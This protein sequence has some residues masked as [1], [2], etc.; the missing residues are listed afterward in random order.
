MKLKKL[1]VLNQFIP[2]ELIKINCRIIDYNNRSLKIDF[3]ADLF[4]SFYI[5]YLRIKNDD[6]Q[7]LVNLSSLI[8]KE[9]F[10][11]YYNCYVDYLVT[12]KFITKELNHIGGGRCRGYKLNTEKLKKSYIVPY[13]NKNNKLLRFYNSD[14]YKDLQLKNSPYSKSLSKYIVNNLSHITIDFEKSINYMNSIFTTDEDKLSR[15]YLSNIH[16]LKNI[17]DDNFHVVF[18]RYGRVHSNF[19]T[20]KKEIRN[21]Y[22]YIDNEITHERD[23]VSSQAMFLLYLLSQEKNTGIDRIE[24]REFQ[25]DIVGGTFYENL[26]SV[27]RTRKDVKVYFYKYLFGTKYQKFDEFTNRYPTISTFIF[28]YK[29]KY[30]YKEISHKLQHMEGD[31]VFNN[32]CQQLMDKHEVF[33]TVHDSIVVKKSDSATLNKIF[34]SALISLKMQINANL[35]KNY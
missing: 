20:L 13:Q 33:F 35:K 25:S 32:V 34:D 19:T 9:K 11:T 26:M 17:R 21:N 14:Y 30:G 4:H 22:I 6:E 5:Q 8:L 2:N 24:I 10:G 12:N 1:N 3:I 28:N 7:I 31:F 15:K 27:D 29:S 16:S 23:I 18:D